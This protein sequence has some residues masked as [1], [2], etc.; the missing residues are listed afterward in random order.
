[1]EKQTLAEFEAAAA[2]E[3]STES[4]CAIL[5]KRWAE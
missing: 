1:M 2:N 4:H 3:P 5:P